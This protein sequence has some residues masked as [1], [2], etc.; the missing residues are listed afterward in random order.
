MKCGYCG[1]EIL[2]TSKFCSQCGAKVA[3]AA[4]IENTEPNNEFQLDN[5]ESKNV[6]SNDGTLFSE[7]KD[8]PI[9]NE[10]NNTI[11]EM[12]TQSTMGSNVSDLEAPIKEEIN[13][14]LISDIEGVEI[15]SVG[16][17]ITQTEETEKSVEANE[18]ISDFENIDDEKIKNETIPNDDEVVIEEIENNKSSIEESKNNE[19]SNIYGKNLTIETLEEDIKNLYTESSKNTD[20]SNY[21]DILTE[22]GRDDDILNNVDDTILSGMAGGILL[23]ENMEDTKTAEKE[24]INIDLDNNKENNIK[25]EGTEKDIENNIKIDGN[26]IDKNIIIENAQTQT[27]KKFSGF[28]IA[29]FVLS[30]C[31]LFYFDFLLVSI[32]GIVLSSLAIGLFNKETQT[33]KGLAIAGLIISILGFIICLL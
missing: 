1:E 29:G 7:L 10:S 27:T 17:N 6:K 4:P 8:Q 23:N 15:Q 3:I 12:E 16:E 2:D 18:I 5:D 11:Q 24:T 28:A 25:E 9:E 33:G 19:G 13:N 22:A 26:D 30:I 32:L 20:T 31:S 21:G 14:E